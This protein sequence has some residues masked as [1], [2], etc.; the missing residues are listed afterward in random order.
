MQDAELEVTPVKEVEAIQFR[1][2]HVTVRPV[3]AYPALRL[4]E[5]LDAGARE[6]AERACPSQNR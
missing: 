4:D 2:G 5:L 3:L 1:Q 6:G